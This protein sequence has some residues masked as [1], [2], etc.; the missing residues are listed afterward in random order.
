VRHRS[1]GQ[2][3]SCCHAHVWSYSGARA[4]LRNS[5]SYQG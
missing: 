4:A 2:K 1:F 5:L 3:L